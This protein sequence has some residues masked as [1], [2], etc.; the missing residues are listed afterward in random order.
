MIVRPV[1]TRLVLPSELS[2][3]EFL[4]ESIK[5]LEENSVIAISSKVIS[6]CQGRI[7]SPNE[8]DKDSLIMREADYYLP[9]ENS[10][11]GYHFAIN[12]HSL[13]SMAGIDE[14]NGDGYYVLW[15]EDPQKDA[16]EI[17]AYLKKRFGLEN[18][19]VIITDS[20]CMPMR[21]G[22]V[23][24]AI[25]YSGLRP[26]DSYI[27]EPD[28]F[29]RDFKMSRRGVVIGLAG[30]AVLVMG[31]GTEQTPIAIIRDTDFVKFQK[32]D[33]TQEELESFYLSNINEDIFEPFFSA[34]EWL[35]GKRNK[36]N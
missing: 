31:E 20:T 17:R 18:I 7:V 6:L 15:P 27:G 13:A 11:Y 9:A 22:T 36:K 34:V 26:T 2:L 33:P 24:T 8:I 32:S 23:G 5:E 16:N 14:S 28:L 19:G 3:Y 4:D 12:Q 35:P 21:W 29:G 25:A 1:K 30:A 10:K